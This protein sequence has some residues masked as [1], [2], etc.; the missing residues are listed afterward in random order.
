MASPEILQFEQLLAPISDERP[1]G[2]EL[3]DDS[4]LSALYYQIKDA[5][6]AARTA[7]RQAM[8][9]LFADEGEDIQVERP[10]W[11]SVQR[12]AEQVIAEHS[13]DLWVVAWLIEALTRLHGFAG[14]RDGFRLAR[15][16]SYR[17][18]DSIH[19]E[20]DEDGYA[21]TVAQLAGLNGEEA[22]GALIR[23]I[24]DIPI[25]AGTTYSGLS[26]ADYK[27]AIDLEAGDPER[28]A[29]RIEQGAASEAMFQKAVD[30]TPVEFF[31]NLLED[32][33]ACLDEF[34]GLSSVL[35]EKCGE[36]ADGYPAAPPTSNIK[37]VL[38]EC[39]ER[40]TSVARHILNDPEEEPAAAGGDIAATDGNGQAVSSGKVVTREDAFRALLQVAEFFRRTEPHSP[41]SYAL[42]QAVRW[43]RMPLPDLLKELVGDE[44]TREDIFKRTGIPISNSNEDND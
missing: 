38:S 17:Y 25:T 42:E 44:T 21:H 15:E 5:R 6:E 33:D 34:A 4:S 1:G 11:Q 2:V 14:L 37:N 8:Q 9:A 26:S 29:L 43:G 23:P 35:D 22:E 10:D 3:K 39:R 20:P 28:R 27:E 24:E 31:E 36:S 40:V 16:L 13:K 30:E 41:V 12:L 19:P 18:W 32:I 7:E